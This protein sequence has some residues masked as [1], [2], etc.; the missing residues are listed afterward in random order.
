MTILDW[1]TR[2]KA[3]PPRDSWKHDAGIKGQ[4]TLE[5]QAYAAA[6]MEPQ[7]RR[8][9]CAECGGEHFT[10]GGPV[11]RVESNGERA[12]LTQDGAVL[13]CL[14]CGARYYTT[15]DGLRRPAEGAL[16]PAWAM[17][18]LQARMQKAQDAERAERAR[19][20]EEAKRT[21]PGKQPTQFRTP[22]KVDA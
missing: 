3:E 15:R 10:A 6:L 13:S 12:K 9:K 14:G 16:P 4:A 8:D 17:S 11:T 21:K 18:D 19:L 5:Q 1:F 22:P 7:F 2:M 20:Q